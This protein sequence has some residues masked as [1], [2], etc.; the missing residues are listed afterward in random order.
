MHLT[1]VKGIT[2]FKRTMFLLTAII[3]TNLTHVIILKSKVIAGALQ[4]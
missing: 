4:L 1:I 2:D 3:T